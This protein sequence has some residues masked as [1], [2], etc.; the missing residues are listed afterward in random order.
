[1][2]S[3]Y[4]VACHTDNIGAGSTFIAVKGQKEDGSKYILKALQQGATTIVIEK[5]TILSDDVLDALA[6]TRAK[7]LYVD[8]ARQALAQ[9][10]A[11]ALDYPAKKLRI[12][13]ITG[14]KG[15]TTS[16]FLLEHVLRN[17][18]YR[19]ALL[20]TVKNKIL[21]VE[22]KTNLTTQHPDYL[23]NFF[24]LCVENE[25][26][27][28]IMEVAAQATSLHRVAGLEFDGLIF[29]NFDKEHAEFYPTMDEYFAAKV[30][31]LD[32]LKVGAPLLLNADDVRVSDLC[33]KFV[34][35][36]TFGITNADADY[37]A[38]VLGNS[39]EKL[40]MEV[41]SRTLQVRP[42]DSP[43]GERER[44]FD[45]L[46]RIN[47]EK[48]D[49][50]I[51]ADNSLMNSIDVDA[52][53]DSE[54]K[55]R[56]QDGVAQDFS[57]I[58]QQDDLPPFVLRGASE[59]SEL[60]GSVQ[61]EKNTF[62]CPSLV[63][64]YNAYNILG[65]ASLCL[66]LGVT[67]E[68]IAQGLL[69]FTAVPGRLERYDLPNGARC[70]ID[71]AHNPSSHQAVLSMM[72]ELTDHLIVVFGA[73]GDRDKTKRPMMGAIVSTIADVVVITSDNPRSEDPTKII[74]DILAG[75]S[76]DKKHK[77]ICDLDRE[78]AIKKAYAV[79]KPG[80]VIMLLGKG[81]DE[82]QII[83]DQKFDFSE[84]GIIKE[85]E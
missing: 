51:F 77:V 64:A 53:N 49:A 8:N 57:A 69:S 61:I 12:V 47:L 36:K 41:I 54:L 33:E 24:A 79:S 68:K 83:G 84:K 58:H 48:Q 82:Y 7:L 35:A 31:L 21:D 81:P 23:H 59:T 56:G 38:T 40:E 72:R 66:E 2:P 39:I 28:V 73:G 34:D 18:G 63:G 78:Q 4:L 1:M 60:E 3:T 10:S 50:E 22:F 29:T 74:E 14:T 62:I 25:I 9:L 27:M 6:H 42:T 71:Y 85:L 11:R 16:S 70:F 45:S 13:G 20:S 17:A 55:L 67:S 44:E 65:V 37:H 15:K 76:D 80:S 52:C 26:D 43:Q 32:Q 75:I 19:T 5:N 46:K 30:A